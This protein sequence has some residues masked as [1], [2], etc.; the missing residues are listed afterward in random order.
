[1]KTKDRVIFKKSLAAILAPYYANENHKGM[2]TQKFP[3]PF[4]E[5]LRRV[6][7]GRLY[8]DRLR[9]FKKYWCAMLKYYADLGSKP[10]SGD[11]N[12]T[13]EGRQKMT[14]EIIEKFIREGVDEFWFN[15]ISAGFTAWRKQNRIQQRS[16][17]AKK[18]WQK[19]SG[20]PGR[21]ED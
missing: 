6:I 9:S 7:G 20:E 16:D 12:K 1:M 21:Q 8:G 5:C 18:R 11:D 2:K 15:N 3:M 13:D 19:K 4:K 14:Q 17:A 10:A